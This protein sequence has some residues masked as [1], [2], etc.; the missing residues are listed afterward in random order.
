MGG[1]NLGPY[2]HFVKIDYLDLK[3]YLRGKNQFFIRNLKNSTKNDQS[4]KLEP[5]NYKNKLF[6]PEMKLSGETISSFFVLRNL[7][8]R[9]KIFLYELS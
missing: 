9:L 4:W 7:I 3:L 5:K 1:L 8:L 6:R 2:I